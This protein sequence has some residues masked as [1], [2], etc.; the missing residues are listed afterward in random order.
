MFT[1]LHPVFLDPFT[2]LVA[3][4][5]C[6]QGRFFLY[7]RDSAPGKEKMYLICSKLNVSAYMLPGKLLKSLK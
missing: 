2:A 4:I 1:L 7:S 6:M 3:V 5:Q